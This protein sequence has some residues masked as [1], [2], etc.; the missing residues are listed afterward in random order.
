MGNAA[1]RPPVSAYRHPLVDAERCIF[2]VGSAAD[3]C[4]AY[5]LKRT[6]R[7]DGAF[8]CRAVPWALPW[9]PAT[10]AALA[11]KSR[12]I[13]KNNEIY[14]KIPGNPGE[15]IALPGNASETRA[16]IRKP[17]NITAADPPCQS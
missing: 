17:T 15:K 9:V 10:G 4:Y 2:M 12:R 1:T 8:R 14:R 13:P 5:T 6:A 16:M 11:E 3:Q 7:P